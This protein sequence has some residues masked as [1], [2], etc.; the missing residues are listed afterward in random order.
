MNVVAQMLSGIGSTL[1]HP[2][3]AQQVGLVTFP[4]GGGGSHGSDAARDVG[5][6]SVDGDRSCHSNGFA[7][8]RHPRLMP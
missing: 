7:V 3:V 6:R 8:D 4:V 5:Q 2:L 1:A